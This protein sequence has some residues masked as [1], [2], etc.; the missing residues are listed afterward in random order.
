[1]EHEKFTEKISLWLDN[2]LS[3]AEITELQIHLTR[4]AACRQIYQAM[5]RVDDL[6]RRAAA[7]MVEPTPG[8]SPRFEARLAQYTPYDQ[9]R[10]WW[11]MIVLLL[12]V[13]F[14]FVLGAALSSTLLVSLRSIFF[15]GGILYP[16]LAALI[17]SANNLWTFINLGILFAKTCLIIFSQPLFW[18]CVLVAIALAGLWVRMMQ[19]I[20][21]R[22]PINV[23]L[24]V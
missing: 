3:P 4:C 10:L 6:L 18:V 11:G 22:S 16:W 23:E 15:S 7:V 17:E 24:L 1:M 21:R 19:L 8:F 2:E 20:Y 5:Q 14:F 9:R 13:T 12:G